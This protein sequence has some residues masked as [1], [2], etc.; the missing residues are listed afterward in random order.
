MVTAMLLRQILYG[1]DHSLMQYSVPCFAYAWYYP[2]TRCLCTNCTLCAV[3]CSILL[4]D[5]TT[6]IAQPEQT[7]KEALHF[8]GADVGRSVAVE[9]CN[10]A[11]TVLHKLCQ[12]S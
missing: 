4:V 5:Y 3:F 11:R 6:F 1:T 7:V 12:S 9:L 2:L 8:V 10:A